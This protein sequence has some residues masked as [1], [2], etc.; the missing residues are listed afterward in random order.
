MTT[1]LFIIPHR[2][3]G[4]DPYDPPAYRQKKEEPKSDYL[5]NIDC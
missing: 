3:V 1:S 2:F 5:E 4:V